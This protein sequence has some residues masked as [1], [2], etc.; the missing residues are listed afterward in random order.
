M[1]D[2]FALAESE[3]N[4]EALYK[5]YEVFK[6]LLELNEKRLIT[7]LMTD[8]YYKT[9]F[10][11]LEYN[12]SFKSRRFTYRDEIDNESKFHYAYRLKS[13]ALTNKAKL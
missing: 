13:E 8:E 3:E 5:I 12:P 10:G 11:A 7:H 4:M 9:L 1:R 2:L 6:L